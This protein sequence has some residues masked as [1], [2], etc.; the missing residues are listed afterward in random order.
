MAEKFN[1]KKLKV[2]KEEKVCDKNEK[3]EYFVQTY[4]Y[5]NNEPRVR[6]V[7]R[8][9]GYRGDYERP[10]WGG[11]LPDTILQLLPVIKEHANEL[12]EASKKP[13]SKKS[14]KKGEK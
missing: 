10:V 13:S 8:G 2:L 4:T 14:S 3:A 7:E 11:L 5:D 6:V 12:V 9:T 1:A